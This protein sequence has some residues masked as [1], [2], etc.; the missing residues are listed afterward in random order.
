M[1]GNYNSENKMKIPKFIAQIVISLFV[2]F[3]VYGG[4][5]F[6][7]T[8]THA[9]EKKT[10]TDDTHKESNYSS[11]FEASSYNENYGESTYGSS[12][13]SVGYETQS[14]YGT[15]QGRKSTVQADVWYTCTTV[16]TLQVQNCEISNTV[17]TQRGSVYVSYY[18]VCRSCHAVGNLD[19]SST[20]PNYPISKSYYC[21]ECGAMTMVK[22]KMYF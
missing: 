2:F 10:K 4:I 5:I 1:N 22:L 8:P 20:S 7:S 15:S 16:D 13:S 18:P 12:E 17:P 19:L 21:D 11:G 14:N 9:A 3:L 6:V